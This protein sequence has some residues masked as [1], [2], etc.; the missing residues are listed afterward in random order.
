MSM[1]S[2]SMKALDILREDDGLALYRGARGA[3]GAPMLAL[4]ASDAGRKS[5]LQRLEREFAQRDLLDARWAARPLALEAEGGAPT[6]WLTDPQG[7]LLSGRIGRPWEISPFLRVAVGIASALGGVHRAG[8]MHRDLKPDNVLADLESGSAWLTG[9]SFSS[10]LLRERQ[11]LGPPEVIAGTLAYMAPEQTGRM[12]R[13]MD[14]RSDLYALGVMFY[15]MLAGVLPFNASDPL[16]WIH[17]HVA[18]QAVHLCE[19]QPSLPPALAAIVMKLLAKTGEDRYQTAA[20]LEADLRRCR[21]EWASR[22]A[23]ADFRLGMD[24][25]SSRLAMPERLYGRD[26]AIATLS[27]AFERVAARGDFEFTLVSG[28]AGIGKSS[29][30]HELH[31]AVV[32]PRGLFVSGKFDQRLR[33]TPYSTLAEAFRGL[34]SQFLGGDAASVARWR[35]RID[36]AVGNHCSLLFELLPELVALMGPQPPLP[37]LSPAEATTRFQSA[38]QRFIGAFAREDQPLVVF[39][40]DLQWLDP[41]TLSLVE[42]IAVAPQT[43]HVHLIG[44]Y[45]DNDVQASHPLM[46]AVA[47]IRA[48]GRRVDNL[49]LGPLDVEDLALLLADALRLTCDQ[50][51]PLAALV[52]EKTGG[53]PFFA[54]QFLANLEEEGLVRFDAGSLLWTWDAQAIAATSQTDNLLDLT[55]RRLWRLPS[56]TQDVLRVLSCLGRHTDFATLATLCAPAPDLHAH[57]G[58]AVDAGIVIADETHC[59][60]LHDRVQEG[61]YALVPEGD[62]G[63]L[64]LKIGRVLSKAMSREALAERIFDVASQLNLGLALVSDDEERA[65]IA[66]LDLQAARRAKASTAYE[67]ACSYLRA[68]LAALGPEGW[69]RAYELAFTTRCELAECEISRGRL[70]EAGALVD[71]MLR[72]SRSTIAFAQATVLQMTVQM[73]RGEVGQ[74]VR[75]AIECLGKFGHVVPERP[76]AADVGAECE[77]LYEALGD[78]TIESLVDLPPMDDPEAAAAMSV[79]VRLGL[80]SYFTDGNL[81]QTIAIRLVRLTLAHGLCESSIYGCAG[82]GSCLGP[83]FDRPDDAVRFA[84]AGIAIAD[85]GGHLAFRAGAHVALQQAVL[86]RRPVAEAV[87]LLDDSIRLAKETGALI[88]ACYAVEHRLTDMLFRGDPLDAMWHESLAGLA[89]TEKCNVRHA[90]DIIAS[91][92]GFI[93]A[94]QGHPDDASALDGR[95]DARIQASGIPVVACFHGI[96][97]M[98][99]L[100]LLGDP[101]GALAWAERLSPILWSARCHIQS[102]HHCVFQSLAIAA[103]HAGADR[104]RQLEWR[105]TLEA[106]LA[107]LAHWAGNCPSSFAHRHAL[108]AAELARLDGRGMEALRLYEQAI[109]AATDNGF[110]QD[111]ALSCEFAGAFCLSQGLA[112]AGRAHLRDARRSYLLWGAHRKVALLDDRYPGLGEAAPP[113]HPPTIEAPLAQVDFATIVKLSQTL[114]GEIVHDRLIERLMT[115]SLEHAAAERGLLALR[116]RDGIFLEAVA[117]SKGD[118]V[119]VER[120]NRPLAPTDMPDAILQHVFRRRGSVILDD[121]RQPNAFS[122][123]EYV[124]QKRPRSVL[125]LPLVKQGQL[126]GALYFENNLASHVF[127]PVRQAV[128]DM[129]SSQAVI[130]LQNA[131]LVATLEQEVAE[132]KQSEA[133]LRESE[134][135]YALAIEAAADGHGYWSA[136]TDEYYCSPRWIEQWNMPPAPPKATRQQMFELFPW[137]PDDRAT[138]VALHER[139]RASGA[140]RLEFE[141]RVV[142]R[143]EV[144]WMHATTLYVRDASGKI[145]RSS[146]ATTDITARRQ[147]EEERR[148]SEE[149]YALALAGSDESIYDWDLKTNRL[150]IA[151]R[152]QELLGLP[153]GEVWRD[154]AEWALVMRYHPDDAPGRRAAMEAHIAGKTPKY[155]IEVRILVPGGVRWLHQRGRALRDADGRAYRVVGSVGDITERKREQEEMQRLE[156]RL[157]QAERFEAMGTLAGGIAH[158]FNNIL[159]AILGFGERALRAVAEGSRLHHDIANV[160]VAGE[161][162]RTLVERILSFSRGAGERVPVHVEKVVR[163]ALDHLQASLPPKVTLHARLHAGHAAVQGDA[164]Q[165]HQL[166]MNL[167]T[168]AVHAMPEGGVLSVAL[169]AIEVVDRLH[170]TT[171]TVAPGPWIVLRVSDEGTGIPPE[172]LPRIFDPF[173]TTKEAHVGTGL[174]LALV[175]RIVAEVSGVIDVDSQPGIGTTFTVHLP[176]AGDASDELHDKESSSPAGQGQRILVVDDEESLLEL[177]A[178]TLRDLGY[179]PIGFSSA[180]AALREF[181]ADPD[182]FDAVITDQRMPDMAGDRLI[183]EIRLVRPSMPVILVSGYV[184]DVAAWA[185]DVGRANEILVKP[186]RANALATS[187]A[188]LLGGD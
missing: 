183:R 158:D 102:V 131:D 94:L 172:I 123:D 34:I 17:C 8:L 62:R 57:I 100:F 39:L 33:D 111:R 164:T 59:R 53:N 122:G 80:A 4:V 26:A 10:R 28:Y 20:G 25:V 136:E 60:F 170:A 117:G 139:H 109:R 125:C 181:R 13:S 83:V 70:D 99:R 97:Q 1:P 188:R 5:L 176:R 103:L 108:V 44:A 127:T 152:T 146:T 124:R 68:G 49:E 126:I 107:V 47:A 45:R 76:S 135:R 177:T 185:S 16:E 129:L 22:A 147:A 120:V 56:R 171:G 43:H 142:V 38:F 137:H 187:L 106:N 166:L 24:D 121:A 9:F 167:G 178:D 128:L 144:R 84:R 54:G 64:H 130:S 174:G 6:L 145:V 113:A 157:R 91:M 74:V 82:L 169:D 110:V 15:E 87:A 151:P 32:Q 119:H 58:H 67:G 66:E 179:R 86:W 173:F 88:F 90:G 148:L 30:V 77:S 81:N 65:R 105:A 40:D 180:T 85:K 55:V 14:S 182:A 72:R 75:T 79:M 149:R 98:Q 118:G 134:A 78:R 42:Y 93:Q 36:E 46:K 51:R 7:E 11:A 19:R 184:G 37:A 140:K 154:R 163:E 168:N 41:A 133:A 89:F 150:Y 29:I 114:S 27:E 153:I 2:P 115:I 186:L 50:A 3:D 23:I 138:I 175:L 165:I 92:Q 69:E 52:R 161:R 18:R 95:I 112:S 143:G 104:D 155:D 35:Q 96:L 159:G 73:M 31:R 156:S 162:G 61:A 116:R 21:Q 12:N 48:S 101:A 63:A 132:R 160:I 71:E 141:T